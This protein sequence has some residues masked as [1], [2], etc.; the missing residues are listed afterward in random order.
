M[1]C[2]NY[3]FATSLLP[4]VKLISKVY[5][6]QFK[7]YEFIIALLILKYNHQSAQMQS[8]LSAPK[9]AQTPS[10]NQRAFGRIFRIIAIFRIAGSRPSPSWLTER[11][12]HHFIRNFALC[13]SPARWHGPLRS[14]RPQRCAPPG[15]R[16]HR[17][18]PQGSGCH[19]SG[20]IGFRPGGSFRYPG[21][22]SGRSPPSARAAH[23]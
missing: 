7:M 21:K 15:I 16:S 9:Y 5:D 8:R 17:P 13:L 10:E 14:G 1:A 19:H 18:P 4:H 23:R 22:W 12:C 20:T 6:S 11:A 2:N 3:P